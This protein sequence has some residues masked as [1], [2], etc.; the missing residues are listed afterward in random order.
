MVPS[1]LGG[2]KQIWR[3]EGLPGF[4]T[5]YKATLMRDVPYTM[6]ELGL[7]DNFKTLIKKV[8]PWVRGSWGGDVYLSMYA[9]SSNN[10]NDRR[11]DVTM[12]AP[13]NSNM[14]KIVPEARE[15]DDGRG[16]GGRGGDGR[17]R[18]ARDQPAGPRQD[19]AHDRGT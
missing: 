7:Y 4:F 19:A 17:D 13:P 2:I 9:S 10:N 11:P 5:G 18:G 8:G 3:T 12:T 1:L 16:A 15:P 14:P 6:L